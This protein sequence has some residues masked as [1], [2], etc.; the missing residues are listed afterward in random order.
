M[1][2]L[3]I[4]L[5]VIGCILLTTL[6]AG[7]IVRM[8][9]AETASGSLSVI[10]M[11]SWP[12]E[13]IEEALLTAAPTYTGD[14][15]DD[16]L[17][18]LEFLVE[19]QN[20][21]SV[22][23]MEYGS[24]SFEKGYGVLVDCTLDLLYEWPSPRL[25]A[26]IQERL[27]APPGHRL[28]AALLG[29]AAVA[30]DP[31]ITAAISDAIV[32][33]VQAGDDACVV[34]GILAL[35]ESRELGI[36]AKLESFLADP[37]PAR[38]EAARRALLAQHVAL[39]EMMIPPLDNEAEVPVGCALGANL[40]FDYRSLP[41]APVTNAT[42]GFLAVTLDAR[43]SFTTD[44]LESME[45][46]LASGGTVLIAKPKVGNWPA[47]LVGWAAKNA[48]VLPSQQREA[49]GIGVVRYVDYRVFANYPYELRDQPGRAADLC[50]LEW[51]APWVAP[52]L[53]GNGAGALIL[54]QEGVLDK[55]RLVLTT[56]DLANRPIYREN[57][58][59][60]V[61]GDAL[62]AHAF[63]F[64]MD[65]SFQPT[66]H[67]EHVPWLNPISGTKPKVLYLTSSLFKRGLLELLQRLELDWRYVPYDA[68]FALPATKNKPG[69]PARM[70]QRA[71]CLLEA[72]IPW[73]DV[74]VAD[75]GSQNLI[76]S[77]TQDI[78]GAMSLDTVPARLRRAIYRRVHAEGMGVLA[79]SAPRFIENGLQEFVARATGTHEEMVALSAYTSTLDPFN[80]DD[81]MTFYTTRRGK[82]RLCW[83]NRTLPH[84]EPM[85]RNRASMPEAFTVAGLYKPQ[86]PVDRCEYDYA[87][88]AKSVL[89]T[90]GNHRVEIVKEIVVAPSVADK[91][92]GIQVILSTPFKGTIEVVFRDRYNETTLSKSAPVDGASIS[93]KGP[94]LAEGP[95]VAE[96]RLMDA[97]ACVRDA[98]AVRLDVAGSVRIETV[99]PEQR[100][101]APGETAILN[102]VLSAPFAGTLQVE[103][104]DTFGRRVFVLDRN[105]SKPIRD[106]RLEIPIRNPL[107]RL[108]DAHVRLLD[109]GRVLSHVRQSIGVR[110]PPAERDFD[111]TASI[112]DY[113]LVPFFRDRMAVNVTYGDAELALRQNLELSA[114]SWSDA[115]GISP[116]PGVRLNPRKREPCLS[117]PDFRMRAIHDMRTKGQRFL[118]LGIRDYMI[119]DECSL[120]GR[121]FAPV[122]LSRFRIKMREV[123]GSL[124]SLN[125]EWKTAYTH[126]D[127]VQPCQ[128]ESMEHPG[129]VVDFDIF[130]SWVFAE[131][132]SYLEM[133]AGD[134]M[135]NFYAGQ[136]GGV[137]D[138]MMMHQA[139]ALF[140]YGVNERAV[141]M[142]Q[143]DAVIGSWYA[144]GYRFKETHEGESRRWPWW[145]LFRGTTRI[146]LWY[147]GS[148]PPAY[149][150]DLSRPYK[151]FIWLA[152]EM[153][154]MRLGIGKLLLHANRDDGR[155]AIYFSQRSQFVRAALH[156]ILTATGDAVPARD[157]S[158]AVGKRFQQAILEEQVECR[159][160]SEYQAEEGLIDKRGLKLIVMPGAISLS[161]K[162]RVALRAFVESGGVLVADKTAGVRNEHGTLLEQGLVEALTGVAPGATSSPAFTPCGK[163]RV[164][165]VDFAAL[166][167]IG[168]G[169]AAAIAW[170]QL[171]S[172]LL[173]MADIKPVVSVVDAQQKPIAMDFGNFRDGD[174]LYAGFVEPGRGKLLSEDTARSVTVVFPVSAHIYDVRRGTYLGQVPSL[175]T[176][177]MPSIA[178]IYAALPWRL[179]GLDV[180]PGNG[181]TAAVGTSV[182]C[183][184][185]AR[186][187]GP[188][189]GLQ[190]WLVQVWDPSGEPQPAYTQRL[191]VRGGETKIVIP[192]A[193]NAA[194][195]EWKIAVRDA[196]TGVTGQSTIEIK[197]ALL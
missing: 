113:T 154:N 90:L 47:A 170:K 134:W 27:K 156:D 3:N 56:V 164:G 171:A 75:A 18:I 72:S 91:P 159:F 41:T 178:Q 58:L 192:F 48:V 40:F 107:A 120:G 121:C 89:W 51:K 102:V 108:W 133:L 197:E 179:D 105:L 17:G 181:G 23:E 44:M 86:W 73:A 174:A 145:H 187:T 188:K 87:L 185:R 97:A 152:E 146:Q 29:A 101:Y 196:A 38:R 55:G 119:D 124:D 191:V 149:H 157:K 61:Y 160:L 189:P 139:G 54:L 142:K 151:A 15:P 137:S 62:L 85:G 69:P 6:M 37:V 116:S 53:A 93:W 16:L 123:Y 94:S 190:I 4:R 43:M 100:F 78:K 140:Y 167:A 19:R 118:D 52:V 11:V 158:Q 20:A 172:K 1:M 106:C 161:E 122:T 30:T 92:I 79:V 117:S 13:K 114:G 57:L 150:E 12:Q 104:E 66:G 103:V 144:P 110:L 88:L 59:R 166:M 26:L 109:D 71:V 31:G 132:C 36:V 148:G 45:R 169:D 177:V 63:Q 74:L 24:E 98:A 138:N 129:T 35:G 60:W 184:I 84:L 34:V 112:S 168:K 111:V 173:R 163:G 33:A 7:G 141:S 193:L 49:Y 115:L 22:K 127:D 99:T 175:T 176:G 28:Q 42:L 162:E 128:G 10:E 67:T 21:S 96:I 155:T 153:E 143:L 180:E 68:S 125:R 83:F 182:D 147:P 165:V 8:A 131:Y 39:G 81:D 183:V 46:T 70:A 82:G 64:T 95:Y 195:G 77:L 50:W 14:F 9:S 76:K 2:T 80:D 136:S 65:Y 25:T 194:P 135:E 32:R 130:T 5:R 126:W 186:V